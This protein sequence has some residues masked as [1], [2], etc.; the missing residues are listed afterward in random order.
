M[1]CVKAEYDICQEWGQN[2]EME[3]RRE[4]LNVMEC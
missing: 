2:R 1:I 4:F 3:G